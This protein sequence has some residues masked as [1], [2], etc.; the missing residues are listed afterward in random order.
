M[1]VNTDKK[2]LHFL[3]IALLSAVLGAC[4]PACKTFFAN[5]KNEQNNWELQGF[6]ESQGDGS[7]RVA[8]LSLAAEDYQG[9]SSRGSPIQWQPLL[10]PLRGGLLLTDRQ[11]ALGT[12]GPLGNIESRLPESGQ[13]LQLS[14]S[15]TSATGSEKT[16]ES[17][18][19]VEFA[20]ADENGRRASGAGG[21]LFLVHDQVSRF[22]RAVGFWD[23]SGQAQCALPVGRWFLSTGFGEARTHM[24]FVVAANRENKFSL[25]AL[26]R[27]RLIVRL[28]KETGLE[29]GDI[30][31]IGRI[32]TP[33]PASQSAEQ[34]PE[35]PLLIQ[36]DLMRPVLTPSE[37]NGVREYLFTSILLHRPEFTLPLEAGEYSIG[38]WRD[39]TIKR[40]NARIVIQPSD[41]ALLACDAEMN[42]SAA[43]ADA[44]GQSENRTLVF[45]DANHR[46]II[47]DGTFLPSRLINNNSLRAW[48]AK[49]GVNRFLR[50]G[51]SPENNQ[52]KQMQ[53]ILQP[54]LQA[55]QAER[56]IPPEGPFMG[57]FSLSQK[58][59]TD[60][61]TGKAPFARLLYAQSGLNLDSLLARVFK[62]VFSGTI[63][64]A[65]ISE[66][67]LLEGVVP[68]TFRTVMRTSEAG[69]L[70]GD[71]T[72]VYATNGAHIDWVEPSPI[73]S[74]FPMRLGPQ[75]RIRVRLR[76]PP[77]DT[78]EYFSMFINGER[79]KQWSVP[80]SQY[81]NMTRT[82]EIDEKINQ[83]SDFFVGFS[84]WGKTY[85]PE[86]MFG[87]RQLPSVSFTRIYCIDTNENG[88]CDR[89]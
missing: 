29:F 80:L 87:V 62:P 49:N 53:F 44:F 6:P 83:T 50:A 59:E 18:V 37:N 82:L 64:L 39:G 45:S 68:M 25:K 34:L 89:I 70:R 32:R 71:E 22:V 61:K 38:L 14:S 9:L 42:R 58:S 72:E 20:L 77:E 8:L 27:A 4:M 19:K 11:F 54:F 79:Y 30:L 55:V 60:E 24:P 73:S 66:R 81:R 7:T 51:R 33:Q 35:V 21:Q 74:G 5:D 40:C 43:A 85:L 57:D 41:V 56:I 13:C 31:R 88:L 46:S 12:S 47:F 2:K 78:T 17:G 63:P 75:Q 16:A 10:M 84:S 48:M 69:K 65:G 86:Y 52:H 67:G 36:D 1:I 28:G 76:V 26:S 23:E 3:R 15:S